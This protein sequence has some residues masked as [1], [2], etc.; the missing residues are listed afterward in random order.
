MAHDS[1]A[2]IK[3][4]EHQKT[5]REPLYVIVPCYNEERTVFALLERCLEADVSSLD[6]EKQV[7]VVDDGSTDGSAAAI[8]RFLQI[9]WVDFFKAI[10]TLTKVRWQWARAG[11]RR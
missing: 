3:G 11:R 10:H 4:A 6:L 8:D 7:I 9:R 1:D 2:G 5:E